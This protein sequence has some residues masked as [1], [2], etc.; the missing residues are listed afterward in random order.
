MRKSALSSL[1]LII[2]NLAWYTQAWNDQSNKIKLKD[3]HV[4]TLKKGHMTQGRRSA[5]VPQLNCVGG[6][7]G[8]YKFQPKTV[9]C[10][11]KGFDGIDYQWECKTDMDDSYRFGEIAVSCEGYDYPNDEYVLAGSCGLNYKID[12][13]EAG[14]KRQQWGSSY[15]GSSDYSGLFIPVIAFIAVI[16]LCK[17]LKANVDNHDEDDIHG[18]G[19]QNRWGTQR[20]PHPGMQPPPYG[21]KPEYTQSPPPSYNDTYR[22]QGENSSGFWTG[23]GLG[24]LGGYMFGNTRTRS[25]YRRGGCDPWGGYST[26]YTRNRSSS[27]GTSRS[28]SGFGGTTR[29]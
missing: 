12:Y 19:N 15:E 13:T 8:C 10:I 6:T 17:F 23:M 16:M 20:G 7:A 29:R 14:S 9:Q 11:N 4:L 18:H 22:R 26:T 28:V 2:A 5:P 27:P 25:P 21:F 24:A 1:I 3:V